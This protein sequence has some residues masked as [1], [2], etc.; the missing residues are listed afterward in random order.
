MFTK[1]SGQSATGYLY[2]AHSYILWLFYLLCSFLAA[3]LLMLIF[4][5]VN[6]TVKFSEG[7][8]I[9][10]N[11]Q[12]DYKAPF[13]ASLTAV[14]VKAGDKVKKGDTLVIIVN[15][16]LRTQF[17]NEK[18]EV[19]RLRLQIASLNN[20]LK[21]I[22]TKTVALHGEK[23]LSSNKK[24]LQEQSMQNSL[25]ALQQQ[26]SLQMQKLQSAIER[27]N[28]DSVLYNKDMISKME[29]NEG[30]D[31]TRDLQKELA[32]TAALIS[33]ARAEI[34]LNT[35]G[36]KKELQELSLRGTETVL[37]QQVLLKQKADAENKLKQSEQNVA[38]LAY[39]TDQQYL[40]AAVDGTV[41]F[42]FNN[43]QVVNVI[44]KDE[45]L[46]TIVPASGTFYARAYLPEK[47]VLYVQHNMPALVKPGV[48]FAEKAEVI[49]G[50]VSYVSE[51][52]D[53]NRFYALIQLDNVHARLLKPGYAVEGEIVTA[54][55]PLYKFFLR[56]MFAKD[57]VVKKI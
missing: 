2:D 55:L 4:I 49:K 12:T 11:P 33:K 25:I 53:S 41:N 16:E 38:L 39:K 8:I 24:D 45:L 26:Y 54:Q 18:T 9:A 36:Y 30:K 43:V 48:L 29:F 52:K 50:T 13:E 35:T 3:V 51:R 22:D 32:N 37:E 28:A 6:D 7:E 40:T 57:K 21:T 46:V 42:V 47:D 5:K 15:K 17:E 44:N 10:A 19:Q 14:K 20:L 27:N 31:A 23:G 1:R 34:K 56:K